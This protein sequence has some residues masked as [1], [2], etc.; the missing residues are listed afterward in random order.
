MAIRLKILIG[1]GELLVNGEGAP[2]RADFRYDLVFAV[3][4]CDP[5]GELLQHV[6]E[7]A[8]FRGVRA[9]KLRI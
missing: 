3:S 9:K 6:I 7:A 4:L 2:P 1:S 8:H 5:P